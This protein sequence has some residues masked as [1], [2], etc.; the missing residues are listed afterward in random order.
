MNTRCIVTILTACL[1]A[2]CS[3]ATEENNGATDN[4]ANDNA[5][6]DN[7]ANSDSS[8]NYD[9]LVINEVAAKG[10]P[11]DWFELKNTSDAA[12]DL[13]GCTFSDDLMD[14]AKATFEDGA[15]V[16]A[17]GYLVVDVSDETAG[18]GLGSDEELGVFAPDGSVIDSVDWDDGA[19]PE[20]GS[21]GRTPDGTGDFA[22]LAVATRGAE[23]GDVASNGFTT[24]MCGDDT[25]EGEEECDGA[26]LGDAT[27]EALGFVGGEIGCTMNCTVDTSSCEVAVG[28][29]VIN[30]VT[31]AG[32]DNI[33]LYNA[34]DA[35]VDLEGW[36]VADANYPAEVDSR[37][38]FP[39]GVMLGAG[40][41]LVLTKDVEHVFGI[42]KDDTI[43]LYSADEIVIDQVAIP[44]GAAEI[45]Y[46]RATDGAGDFT[47]CSEATFGAANVP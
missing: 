24:P 42:G 27:C 25:I 45:S 8:G 9:G 12:I 36:F 1:L 39:A 38:V 15:L 18:F 6:N 3:G 11:N 21:Y 43:T 5:A 30:E 2:A 19:S 20:G 32:D 34:G 7:G 16:P 14:S 28:D 29:V 41:W 35:A 4:A 23:N 22:T 33:E 44:E 46:C 31:S 13:T 17:G 47:T 26:D 40:E 10:D 37:Y